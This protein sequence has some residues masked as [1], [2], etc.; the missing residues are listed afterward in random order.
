MKKCLSCG[1]KNVTKAKND[2]GFFKDGKSRPVR[3]YQHACDDCG[4]VAT[5]KEQKDGE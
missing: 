1:S 4:L 5:F 3:L 2:S